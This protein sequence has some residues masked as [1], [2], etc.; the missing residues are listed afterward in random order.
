MG[1]VIPPAVLAQLTDHLAVPRQL[2]GE[3]AWT[4]ACQRGGA[5]QLDT[6]VEYALEER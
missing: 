6:A 5:M 1:I 3:A 4:A 2:H